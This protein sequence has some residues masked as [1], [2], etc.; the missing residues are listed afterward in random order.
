M[1]S[2]CI[3]MH[4]YPWVQGLAVREKAIG[5][6][7]YIKDKSKS[8]AV[9]VQCDEALGLVGYSSP[10]QSRGIRILSIDGGGMRGLIAIEM[11][12]TFELQT[13]KRIY[14]VLHLLKKLG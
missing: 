10:P 12:K 3:H 8:E 5:K 6:I 7:L 14:E 1:E 11:L 9:K 13:G 2:F 4:A